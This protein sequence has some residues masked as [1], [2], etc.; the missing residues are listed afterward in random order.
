[1]KKFLILLLAVCMIFTITAC[2]N[3]KPD[4]SNTNPT[5]NNDVEI[6]QD[7]VD[8]QTTIE[9]I[10][11]ALL[12]IETNKFANMCF[13]DTYN[14]S[15]LTPSD[16]GTAMTL[17]IYTNNNEIPL[18]QIEKITIKASNNT[19]MNMST[20][21]YI[22][23]NQKGCI[24]FTKTEGIHTM[25]EFAVEIKTYDGKKILIPIKNA[26]E[27]S[28]V[29]KYCTNISD[30]GYGDLVKVKN[31]YYFILQSG[32]VSSALFGQD[33][34]SYSEL[35]IATSLIPLKN[36]YT[37]SLYSS[38]FET[39]FID[40]EKLGNYDVKTT[41]KVNDEE[42]MTNF[43]TCFSGLFA[44][45]ITHTFTIEVDGEVSA[46]QITARRDY[47]MNNTWLKAKFAENW[48]YKPYTN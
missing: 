21:S 19:P 42:M 31:D 40:T 29:D 32:S 48:L 35:I 13:D 5:G 41:L 38:D 22:L 6:N 8:G 33:G 45:F 15:T 27:M 47:V 20:R 1:M 24:V 44:E 26:K 9:N 30:A 4:D 18:S 46:E 12:S 17:L 2:K 7:N 25:D 28:F 3:N 23:N 43:S 14:K 16:D 39:K 37:H 10:S 34:K 11:V 36:T